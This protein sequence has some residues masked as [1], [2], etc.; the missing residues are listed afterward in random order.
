MKRFDEFDV[1]AL[2]A[3]GKWGNESCLLG[4][5]RNTKKMRRKRRSDD[6][7]YEEEE[8]QEDAYYNHD[9]LFNYNDT[10]DEYSSVNIKTEVEFDDP[11]I[12]ETST[13]PVIAES[14][15]LPEAKR[16][17][18]SLEG[19]GETEGGNG[20]EEN[21]KALRQHTAAIVGLTESINLLTDVIRSYMS[22]K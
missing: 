2:K 22:N 3:L 1:R 13:V 18:V 8:R 17:K 6:D 14:I 7:G 5:N 12:A 16:R 10:A 20:L 9:E 4:K 19:T 15:S 21:T 11:L